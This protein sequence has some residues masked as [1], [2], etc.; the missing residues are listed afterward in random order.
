M[1]YVRAND[2]TSRRI[3]T[4]IIVMEVEIKA[5]MLES[6]YLTWRKVKF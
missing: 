5:N 6:N 2:G 4:R 3:I 1:W